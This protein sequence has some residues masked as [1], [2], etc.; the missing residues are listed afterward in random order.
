MNLYILIDIGRY[1]EDSEKLQ[2]IN[3]SSFISRITG[4]L[5][6]DK[7]CEHANFQA[8]CPHFLTLKE[9]FGFRFTKYN[10]YLWVE[11]L[12]NDLFDIVKTCHFTPLTI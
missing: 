7:Y 3:S 10:Q 6:I 8:V 2:L 11:Y 4:L 1:S 12:L 9:N 5:E